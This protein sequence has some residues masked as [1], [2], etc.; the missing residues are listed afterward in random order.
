VQSETVRLAVS[1][2]AAL[3]CATAPLARAD[4]VDTAPEPDPPSVAT[5]PGQP[6]FFDV[7]VNLVASDA[8]L[9]H[10]ADDG[11]VW[12]DVEDLQRERLSGFTGARR[13]VDGRTLVSLRSL[14]PDLTFEVDHD[15]LVLRITAGAMLLGRARLDLAPHA[16]PP[17]LTIAPAPGLFLNYS[18]V[19]ATSTDPSGAAELGA[20][21]GTGLFLTSATWGPLGAVRGLS[22]FT[23]DRVAALQRFS[24]GDVQAF[25]DALGGN[26]V[27]LG[28][29]AAKDFSLDPYFV[30]A[31]LPTATGFAS[32]PSV[33]EV[34]VNGALVREIPVQ[35]G[36]YELANI[37][38][39]TGA[40]DVRTVVRD[41]FGRTQ[42]MD[43]T[44]YLATGQL[45][46]GLQDWS[47]Q[48]G[49]VRNEFGRESFSYG[50]PFFLGRHRAGL[51]ERITTSLRLEAGSDDDRLV[52]GGGG[53]VASLPI[54]ELEVLAAG[55]RAGARSGAAG[56]AALRFGSQAFTGTT[57]VRFLS[58]RY[59]NVSLAPEQ[60]REI[61]RA[62]VSVG[63]PSRWGTISVDYSAGHPRTG[64]LREQGGIRLGFSLGEGATFLL[65]ATGARGPGQPSELGVLGTILFSAGQRTLV[66]ATAAIRGRDQG[67]RSAS[68]GAQRT[69]LGSEGFGYRVR[70]SVDEEQRSSGSAAV[71]AQRSFGR[72]EAA[73]TQ[74]ADG[75]FSGYATVAGGIGVVANRPFLSR[76]IEQ[77]VALVSV[78]GVPNV[79]TYFENRPVGRTNA[80]GELIVPGLLPYYGHRFA[81]EDTDIPLENRVGE[82][83]RTVAAP[84]RGFTLVKFEVPRM[85]VTTGSLKVA[86]ATD[87]IVPAYG[88]LSVE[89]VTGPV[90]SPIGR[91]GGFWLEGIPPGHHPALVTWDGRT[92]G[93]TLT[94][95]ERDEAVLN[96]G[97]VSCGA[98]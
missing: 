28:A 64:G 1:S 47:F 40:N 65:S 46:P 22:T 27:L 66:D 69:L 51:T 81:I 50:K 75:S 26:A 85:R 16:R 12:I 80:R 13:V 24:G 4:V 90:T 93:F 17:G 14:A 82:V 77:S 79:R 6:A 61:W 45:A 83:R 58:S 39:T 57:H 62:G 59:A 30:R 76:P 25:G 2:L 44:R 8:V 78:P 7:V 32:T 86:G 42:E 74:T 48:A 72:L 21:A 5:A 52:S 91:D 31:P 87:P 49:F 33:L 71:Q 23:W 41:A 84:Y 20:S 73:G 15:K 55:S 53:A 36:S 60:D 95:P 35:P 37:P 92:C 34:W 3:I 11:D 89:L 29:G 98:P 9:V 68:A 97:D 54:G 43:A 67:S 19:A 96:L 88:T 94:V 56:L 63:A 10:L 70:G 18:V 38:V